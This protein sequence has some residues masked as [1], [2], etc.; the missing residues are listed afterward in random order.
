MTD[1]TPASWEIEETLI[2]TALVSLSVVKLSATI[3]PV[4]PLT[5]IL[6]V[7]SPRVM[8]PMGAAAD[9]MLAAVTVE[10]AMVTALAD[11]PLSMMP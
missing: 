4:R 8:L 3:A 7:E 11:W 9:P 10:L 5:A 1:D 2:I 6:S